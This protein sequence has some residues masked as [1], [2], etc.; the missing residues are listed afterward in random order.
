MQDFDRNKYTW[1]PKYKDENNNKY[2]DT[3]SFLNRTTLPEIEIKEILKKRKENIISSR[4]EGRPIN[5]RI[6]NKI[7]QK[8]NDEEG[9][10]EEEKEEECKERQLEGE[11]IT[12]EEP[13]FDINYMYDE[14]NSSVEL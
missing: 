5:V 13:L 12:E 14:K 2:T 9:R 7:Y 11:E 10:V 1:G 6:T 3:Q 4:E 8:N